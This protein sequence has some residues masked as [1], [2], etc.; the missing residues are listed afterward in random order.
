[1]IRIAGQKFPSKDEWIGGFIPGELSCPTQGRRPR[2][3][4][5]IDDVLG[6]LDP[7]Q[8]QDAPAKLAGVQTL[9]RVCDAY[10]LKIRPKANDKALNEQINSVIKLRTIA[11]TCVGHFGAMGATLNKLLTT[12]NDIFEAKKTLAA[13]A[14]ADRTYQNFMAWAK[15]N[16]QYVA[17]ASASGEDIL[18][19]SVRAVPCGGFAHALKSLFETALGTGVPVNY[20][21]LTGYLITDPSYDCFDAT[22]TGNV[23][24]AGSGVHDGRC[25]FN[26]HY[27][28]EFHGKYYDPCMDSTYTVERAV[29]QAGLTKPGGGNVVLPPVPNANDEIYIHSA[30]GIAQGFNG[31][32][33]AV[34]IKNVKSS[35]DLQT[36]L[37][38]PAFN[39]LKQTDI[40]ALVQRCQEINGV[41]ANRGRS[42]SI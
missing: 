8:W 13:P 24:P 41:A 11:A 10:L 27:F 28:I 20:I 21:R 14:V 3:L 35:A 9:V 18:T 37:G 36:A 23:T 5:A 32:W 38:L 7:I 16:C 42:A 17:S 19:G 2:E 31:S 40:D 26:E 39:T 25:I 6:A 15:L 30:S 4:R 33:Y 12:P 29:V 1:M 22:V 34:P